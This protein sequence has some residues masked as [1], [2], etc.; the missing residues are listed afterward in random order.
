MDEKIADMI[1][2][3]EAERKALAD[4]GYRFPA[5]FEAVRFLLEQQASADKG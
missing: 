3:L 1:E 2:H 4:Y 5:L